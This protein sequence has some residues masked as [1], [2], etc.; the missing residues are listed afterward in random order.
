LRAALLAD[1][2]QATLENPFG[3]GFQDYRLDEAS[4]LPA[5]HLGAEARHRIADF[6]ASPGGKSLVLIF[7]LK[8]E[9]SF[10]CNDL[11]PGRVQR[12]KAVFHD[13]LPPQVL[14][15]IDITRS[16]AGRWGL[17]RKE[18]FDRILVDAP[19]SGERHLLQSPNELGRWSLKGAKGL[20]VRQ[21][22]LLCSALD[23]LK[24]GGRLVYSTCS[25]NPM[26]NDGV[27]ERLKESREDLFR[28]GRVEASIGEATENGWIVLPDTAGCGP[29][30]F[31]VL[32]K[33]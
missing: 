25:V 5:E 28:V 4:L 20:A 12:L 33:N 22:A 3:S 24:P 6:C 16:D 23:C 13:C 21:H 27:I 1:P 17:S 10:C 18:E 29:I 7:A 15:K 31:S 32:E 11:S 14:S 8:G 9:G 19:C 26:E 30:Y 2:R